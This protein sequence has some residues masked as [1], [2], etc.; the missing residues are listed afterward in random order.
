MT[1]TILIAALPVLACCSSWAQPAGDSPT[2]EVASVKPSPPPEGGP[3]GF[4]RVSADGGP[5]TNDP[6]RIDYRNMSMGN[7]VVRAYGIKHFQLSGPDWIN[8]EMYDIVAKV[9]PGAT[10]EQFSLMLQNL[11][12]ERF[13]L[14]I[15]RET[16]DLPMY[17]LG[18]A[19]TGKLKPHAEAP[20]PADADKPPA[21]APRPIK[22]DQDGYPVLR[23]GTTM[24]AMNGKARLQVDD[25]D[26]AW[27]V[28]QLSA[29]LGAPVHDDTG[30]KGQYDFALYW[31]TRPPAADADTGPDLF[32]AVTEQIG[33]K[34]E[35]KKGP[36][37]ILVIDHA[38]KV[39]TAN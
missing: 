6:T 28:A 38:E 21:D 30:L 36:V 18:V 23:P 35:K 33:L 37:E 25:K 22:T 10:K 17:Y 13:K 4:F 26:L 2:F 5:G 19:K 16:K 15:H 7:L 12:V 1:R 31:S 14:Q 11:L 27:L 20:P 8:S 9:P 39:P 34:L 3:L 32:A 24:A 29:Q